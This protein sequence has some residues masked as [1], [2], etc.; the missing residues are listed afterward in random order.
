VSGP[1]PPARRNLVKSSRQLAQHAAAAHHI[2]LALEERRELYLT[3]E[4]RYEDNLRIG[5]NQMDWAWL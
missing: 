5:H 1:F 2:Q 3:G 4:L